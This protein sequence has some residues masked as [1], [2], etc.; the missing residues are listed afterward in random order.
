ML[1][2]LSEIGTLDIA[3]TGGEP[4][5]RKDIF[6]ILWYAKRLGLIVT[7]FT[8]GSLINRSIAD[9]FKRLGLRVDISMHGGTKRTFEQIT[10]I[11]GSYEKV[12]EAV[13]LLTARGI[14]LKIKTCAMKENFD[15]LIGISKFA[16]K[17][18]A[19][20]IL[21]TKVVFR[22][23][24]SRDP[25]EHRISPEEAEIV[26]R[27]CY[28]EMYRKTYRNLPRKITPFSSL[29]KIKHCGAGYD[30]T[31][32]NAS[33]ELNICIGMPFPRYPIL[34]GSLKEGWKI[35]KSILD[36]TPPDKSLRCK[37]CEVSRFC[38]RCPARIYLEVGKINS[39]SPMA[40]A[41]ARFNKNHSFV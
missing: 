36:N 11:E 41:E 3:F 39:C 21:D 29:R 6:D 17:I 8:N 35:I 15:E 2:Q 10:G 37:K 28:P 13:D 5:I 38:S 12:M 22:N 33:G 25:L 7:L 31:V 34:N 30:Y 40:F 20:F 14:R 16:R 27:Q 1:N 23:D 9:E 18:K 24:G 4:L 32:I 26:K 19:S